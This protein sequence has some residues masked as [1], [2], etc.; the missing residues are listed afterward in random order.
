M[1]I[2]SEFQYIFLAGYGNSLGDHWQAQWFKKF[3]NA[4]WVEQADWEYPLRNDWVNALDKAIQQSELPIVII[5]HS[6]GCLTFVEWVSAQ[7]F[8]AVPNLVNIKAAFLVA[9]PDC[10]RQGFPDAIRGF[11]R[12]LLRPLPVKTLLVASRNDPY[13]APAR[14][15][16]FMDSWRVN[17]VWLDNAGHI[18]AASGFG[19]WDAGIQL[20][21]ESLRD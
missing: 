8:A 17:L 16:Y 13:C 9:V 12:M 4:I 7:E 6:L 11:D 19:A 3:P 15:Q 14:A 5:A 1:A 2:S 18:N 20:L 21:S 10:E